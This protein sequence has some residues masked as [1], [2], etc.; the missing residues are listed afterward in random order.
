V[1]GDM[2]PKKRGA[3][4]RRFPRED[5]LLGTTCS[6]ALQV[7]FRQPPGPRCFEPR[8]CR[9]KARRCSSKA[10]RVTSERTPSGRRFAPRS[11]PRSSFELHCR[12]T[13]AHKVSIMCSAHNLGRLTEITFHPGSLTRFPTDRA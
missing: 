11:C 8:L 7:P 12:F 3:S 5:G 6:V 10:A 4:L 2:L 1:S 9:G 13:S